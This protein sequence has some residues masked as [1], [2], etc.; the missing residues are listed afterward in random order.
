M[1]ISNGMAILTE[2]QRDYA[3]FWRRLGAALID[4]VLVRL[5]AIFLGAAATGHAFGEIW[6]IQAAYSIG[7]IAFGATPGM[8]L[9]GIRVIDREGNDPGWRRSAIRYII[10]AVSF[11]ATFPLILEPAD[12]LDTG[13]IVRLVMAVASLVLG[14]LD[15]LWMIWDDQKQMLHDKLAH[16]WVIRM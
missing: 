16:T 8:H 9:V 3:S 11:A 1:E 12:A 5:A 2:A 6:M 13:F 15:P 14:I 10:P 4:L 7:F